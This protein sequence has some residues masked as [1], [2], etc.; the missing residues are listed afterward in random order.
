M[1]TILEVLNGE[2]IHAMD[3][4]HLK[5]KLFEKAHINFYHILCVH[6]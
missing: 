5:V 2:I 6:T 3:I 1:Y 4:E